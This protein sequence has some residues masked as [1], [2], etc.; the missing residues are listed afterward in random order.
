M[1]QHDHSLLAIRYSLDL[2]QRIVAEARGW[3]GTPYHHQASRKGVGCDC[4][5]LVRGVW[6]AAIGPEPEVMP[7]YSGDWGAANGADSLLALGQRH[8]TPVDPEAMDAGDVV[9]FR[10]RGGR[11]AKHCGIV[12]SVVW[13]E[14]RF[15]HAQ[16]GVPVAEVALSPWWRQRIAGAFRFPEANSEVA[17]SE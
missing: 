5:G 11:V 14:A 8:F 9:V 1:V 4:V 15:I 12:T 3:I 13:A 7:A 10:M 2:R 16:E 6:R 17:N